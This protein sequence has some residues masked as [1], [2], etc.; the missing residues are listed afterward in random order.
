MIR[1]SHTKRK[2]DCTP[3]PIPGF[4]RSCWIYQVL[5]L[6]FPARQM[7]NE[8]LDDKNYSR[9]RM[10]KYVYSTVGKSIDSMSNSHFHLKVS[11]IVFALMFRFFLLMP[12]VIC[13]RTYNSRT[14]IGHRREYDESK[15][16][17][18]ISHA[19]SSVNENE[20]AK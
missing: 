18:S 19:F 10:I 20:S 17:H 5:P 2:V 12:Y 15:N 7:L 8:L 3:F 13:P 16:A 1:V 9:Y 4:Q 6:R 14:D 11:L